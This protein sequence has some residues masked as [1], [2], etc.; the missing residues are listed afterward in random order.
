K[1]RSKDPQIAD[2]EAKLATVS[3]R[4]YATLVA[5][6]QVRADSRSKENNELDEPLKQLTAERRALYE[7]LKPLHRRWARENRTV[8]DRL[9]KERGAKA[10]VARH[11]SGL[12]HGNYR[13]IMESFEVARQ[14]AL[15][16]GT[17]LRF[18]RRDGSAR[19][20]NVPSLQDASGSRNWVTPAELFA[21]RLYQTQIDPVPDDAFSH[22]SRGYRRP[23][24]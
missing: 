12:W 24:A 18:H 8:L 1:E 20:T 6:S 2:R 13:A 11:A 4:I 14:R 7:E 5:R 3:D 22:P 10:T 9:E 17:E 19:I 23:A 15:K 16:D 21:A